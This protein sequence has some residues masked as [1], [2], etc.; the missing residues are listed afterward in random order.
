MNATCPKCDGHGRI[1]AFNHI[2]NGLCFA[3][4]GVGTYDSAARVAKQD[5]DTKR[6]AE[7]VLASTAESYVGWTTTGNSRSGRSA[8]AGSACKRRTLRCRS[9]GLRLPD[10]PS[11]PLRG[12]GLMDTTPSHPQQQGET[13]PTRQRVH[14][15]GPSRNFA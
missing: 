8:M 9:A 6:K 14:Y 2:A 1:R 13:T 7:W 11:R 3:C 15:P 10:R 5:P 12:R 4:G